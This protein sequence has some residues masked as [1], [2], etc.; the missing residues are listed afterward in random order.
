MPTERTPVVRFSS[1]VKAAIAL[2][3]LC[4]PAFAFGLTDAD[5]NYLAMQSVPKDSAV[6]RALS[7]KE[8]ARL[9]A[10]IT[11][12]ATEHDPAARAKNVADELELY[13][14]HQRWEQEHPGQLWDQ[15]RR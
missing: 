10:I 5:Y 1:V 2:I 13:R 15:P 7:P 11:D 9:H 12:S 8:Q 6:M 14:K 4:A 3:T